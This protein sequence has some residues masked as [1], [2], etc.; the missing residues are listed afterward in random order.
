VVTHGVAAV[1]DHASR[2]AAA[3]EEDTRLAE[4]ARNHKKPFRV[5]KP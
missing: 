2:A 1:A 4:E 3:R 5:F